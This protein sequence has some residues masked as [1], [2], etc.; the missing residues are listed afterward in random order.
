MEQAIN[1]IK[2]NPL[3]QDVQLKI[4]GSIPWAYNIYPKNVPNATGV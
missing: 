1:Q 2:K 4:R 3:Q